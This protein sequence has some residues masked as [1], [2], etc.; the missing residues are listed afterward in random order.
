MENQQERF[1]IM[2][3]LIMLYKIQ[4]ESYQVVFFI[5]LYISRECSCPL[6]TD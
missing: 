4:D 3:L 5:L 1:L 2:L 6:R